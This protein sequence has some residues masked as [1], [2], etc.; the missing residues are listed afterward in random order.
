MPTVTT[1]SVSR[2]PIDRVWN[3]V[4][5]IDT[6]PSYMEEVLD[7]QV[8]E[9]AA[10]TR[11]SKW[12]VLLKGSV[13]EWEEEEFISPERH[14]IEFKQTEGDLAYFNGYWRV[15]EHDGSTHITLHVD[16]D[17]G[18]PLLADMLNPVAARALEEN[19]RKIL[20][21]IDARAAT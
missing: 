21:H 8:I 14:E 19:S 11:R 3:A 20:A 13:L 17:I 15:L 2:H 12:S 6:F 10:G 1:D 7:V 5:A 18:I 4:L 16:F 9:V